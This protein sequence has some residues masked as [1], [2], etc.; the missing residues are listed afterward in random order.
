MGQKSRPMT[1]DIIGIETQVR[2]LEFLISFAHE[3]PNADMDKL[4]AMGTSWGGISN[5][6][7]KMRNDN[8]KAVIC[9]DGS[10]RNEPGFFAKSPYADSSKMNVPF[11]YLA[12]QNLPLEILSSRK[13][14]YSYN[15]YNSLRCSDAY[16][17][18]FNLLLHANLN[19]NYIKLLER[20]IWYENESTQDEVNQSYESMCR[21]ALSFLDGHL[22]DNKQAIAFLRNKP[23]MNGI[24]PHLVTRKYKTAMQPPPA[25]QE[26]KQMLIRANFVNARQ[27]YDELKKSNPDFS[28]KENELDVWGFA[29]AARGKIKEAI[30]VFKLNT[31]LYPGS[32]QVYASLGEAYLNDGNKALAIANLEKSVKLNPQTVWTSAML[33]KLKESK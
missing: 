4:A 30:E 18:T 2:D 16:I 7:L 5:V 33:T 10:I 15:F 29:L 28:L 27:T 11:L 22:K 20:N 1:E 3:L 24:A 23:E 32:S 12:A 8:V 21:Y 14:D 26:F 31:E 6:F 17:I 19:S 25:L 9:L 13:Q